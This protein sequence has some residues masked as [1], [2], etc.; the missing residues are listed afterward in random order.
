MHLQL[1]K[2][3]FMCYIAGPFGILPLVFYSAILI[4]C[5]VTSHSVPMGTYMATH[6][7]ASPFAY[8]HSPT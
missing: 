5:S 1:K 3:T 8:S 7:G 6:V 4:R 2:V